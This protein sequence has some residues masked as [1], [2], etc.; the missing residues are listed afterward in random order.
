VKLRLWLAFTILLTVA[1]SSFADESTKDDAAPK[2]RERKLYLK[3]SGIHGTFYAD[4]TEGRLGFSRKF[5]NHSAINSA[6]VGA[7]YYIND[8][9][10][11][12]ILYHQ[13]FKNKFAGDGQGN[14]SEYKRTSKNDL[15]AVMFGVNMNVVDFD[16]GKLFLGG[17]MGVSQVQEK[18]S[19]DHIKIQKN[20]YS[21]NG[22]K[23]KNF[24]YG[25]GVGAD[26]KIGDR[27]HAEIAY[28]FNDYGTTKSQPQFN[29]ELGKTKLRSHNAMVGVRVDM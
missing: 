12:E 5:K 13:E 10:R 7:G 6:D 9:F 25:L 28:R 2:D 23:K 8:E 15:Y 22:N 17:S 24:S 29:T 19:L 11:A 21:N 1:F 4:K 14:F 20:Y 3:A 18:V 16:Y 27:L 26:F